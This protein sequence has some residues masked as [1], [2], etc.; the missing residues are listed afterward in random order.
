MGI[1]RSIVKYGNVHV[2]IRADGKV[3]FEGD[4]SLGDE[5]RPLDLDVSQVRDLEI[6]VDFGKDLDFGDH[7]D[8][9]DARVIR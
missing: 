8:L 1:D 9:A 4:C 7:L 3:I 6:F 2:I 5:P